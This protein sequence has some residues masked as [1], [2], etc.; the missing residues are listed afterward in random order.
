[1]GHQRLDGDRS[2]AEAFRRWSGSKW[3]AC[4]GWCAHV[5][6]KV[7]DVLPRRDQQ[8]R[9]LELDL[10]KTKGRVRSREA[11]GSRKC[12]EE[13]RGR[14]AGDG[15]LPLLLGLWRWCSPSAKREGE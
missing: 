11:R 12:R 6:A 7:I 1:M 8:W 10:D 9:W 3:A 2:E 15:N 13:S 5:D 4:R 14:P